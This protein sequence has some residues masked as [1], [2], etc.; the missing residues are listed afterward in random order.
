MK[1]LFILIAFAAAA[2][3]G[4]QAQQIPLYSQYWYHQ[5]L[6]NPARAGFNDQAQ[7]YFVYRRQFVGFQE[8]PQ[9]QALTFDMPVMSK[10]AG[11]GVYL[12]NDQSSIF[13]R[14]G[15]NFS[16]A[17][18]FNFADDHRLS[19]G[20]SA[21]LQDIRINYNNVVVRD[22]D[23]EVIM[24]GRRRNSFFEAG[25]GINYFF[26]N[27]NLGLSVPSLFGTDL[28]YLSQSGQA[29]YTM[30]RHYVAQTSYKIKLAQDKFTIEPMA[31]F[32]TTEAFNFQFDVG[33]SFM[34]KDWVWLN[35][36]YR[37]DYA[38]SMGGGFKVHDMITIGYS[39]DLPIN[40]LNNYTTGSHEL[41][42]GVTFGKG[43]KKNDG[44]DEELMKKMADD[45]AKQDSLITELF[46]KLDSLDNRVDTLEEILKNGLEV[47]GE[48][49]ASQDQLDSLNKRIQQL[50]DELN[51]R[52]DSL[53]K[54]ANKTKDKVDDNEERTRIVD[55]NDLVYK[56]GAELGNY[57]M[58]VGSFRIEQNSYNFQEQ[59]TREGFK[60][61]VVYDKK[62][63]W[64][65]VYLSQPDNWEKGLEQLFKLREENER[66]HDAWIHI[67]EKSFK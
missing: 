57:F 62:R 1:K 41:L 11:F 19:L 22:A 53:Q 9:T 59:L 44:V 29:G 16:Y 26:K 65:Y 3:T 20:L 66:F 67:M 34:Y 14:L 8:G 46:Q 51:N 17:Y 58:V 33:A 6:Y 15:G 50:E 25:F 5:F 10:K 40:N 32:R 56:R 63:K 28:R 42:L 52:I 48:G 23:D 18:H 31:M 64:Y 12:F 37:Y 2:F 4:L 35:G 30:K 13:R 60:A 27:W 54:Q 21:G 49:G 47:E 24:N 61:G 36:M 55:E 7:A 43:A 38:V 45:Q 39:Y